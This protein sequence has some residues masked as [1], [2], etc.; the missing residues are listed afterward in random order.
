[1]HPYITY[2]LAREHRL[3]LLRQAQ[4]FS[5]VRARRRVTPFAARGHGGLRSGESQSAVRTNTVA[6][7]S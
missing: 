4:Q 6:R 1:M 7:L 3:D 2:Q 5:G